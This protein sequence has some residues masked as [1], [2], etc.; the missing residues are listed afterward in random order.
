M[1]VASGSWGNMVVLGRPRTELIC[2][3]GHGTL[4]IELL[5][6]TG[7]TAADWRPHDD[8]IWKEL[9]TYR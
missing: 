3:Y 4:E 7:K 5:Q 1:P 8:N 9:E 2:P 6:I